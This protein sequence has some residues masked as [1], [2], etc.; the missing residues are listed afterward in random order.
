MMQFAVWLAHYRITI[1]QRLLNKAHKRSPIH[2]LH[3]SMSSQ[4]AM[5][6]ESA[7]V[8]LLPDS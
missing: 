4:T 5:K 8:T 2:D 1:A 3:G 6:S 7:V